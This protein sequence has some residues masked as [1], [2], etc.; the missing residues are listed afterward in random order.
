[1]QGAYLR[2]E[3]LR[4]VGSSLNRK[5]TMGLKSLAA[6]KHSGLLV[7]NVN[8]KEKKFCDLNASSSTRETQSS[9]PAW[10]TN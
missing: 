8:E 5:Y 1:M 6:E 3:E 4:G 7:R 9:Y 10:L 2:G